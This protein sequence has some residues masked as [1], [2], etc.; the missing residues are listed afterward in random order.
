MTH[1][2]NCYEHKLMYNYMV[3]I[4]FMI[5]AEWLRGGVTVQRMFFQHALDLVALLVKEF[6]RINRKFS[7]CTDKAQYMHSERVPLATWD[8]SW[9]TLLGSDDRTISSIPGCSLRSYP[10]HPMLKTKLFTYFNPI[11]TLLALLFCFCPFSLH[12]IGCRTP[13]GSS[14]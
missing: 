7:T 2:C 13:V 4:C 11:L 12:R 8:V 3:I 5:F 9:A 14:P 10:G 6:P 1:F